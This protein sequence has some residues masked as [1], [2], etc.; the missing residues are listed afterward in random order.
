MYFIIS[1]KAF[2]RAFVD[3]DILKEQNLNELLKER[4]LA[5]F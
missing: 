4:K 1:S 2:V 5:F 3:L